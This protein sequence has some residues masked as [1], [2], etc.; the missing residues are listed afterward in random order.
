MSFLRGKQRKSKDGVSLR[1]LLAQ[2]Y[3]LSPEKLLK[4]IMPVMD[5]LKFYHD[6]GMVYGAITP[7]TLVLRGTVLCL[8]ASGTRLA[9]GIDM[10]GAPED[11]YSPPE[12]WSRDAGRVGPWSDTYALCAVVYEALTG[13]APDNSLIRI[14][15]DE[16]KTP[17]EIGI[18]LAPGVETV[19]MKGL[20]LEPEDRYQTAEELKSSIQDILNRRNRSR[21]IGKYA[22]YTAAVCLLVLGAAGAVRR[23]LEMQDPFYGRETQTVV[24]APVRELSEEAYKQWEKECREK[25]E[26]ICGEEA[27]RV[28]RRNDQ[29]LEITTFYHV[30]D[31]L[32]CK[33]VYEQ[34]FSKPFCPILYT[35]DPET[36]G[37]IKA[38]LDFEAVTDISLLEN[39]T[40]RAER[41][42]S[43]KLELKPEAFEGLRAEFDTYA[44]VELV[45]NE[46]MFSETYY[47]YAEVC[48]DEETSSII[49]G[50]D[51]QQDYW[52]ELLFYELSGGFDE[53]GVEAYLQCEIMADW[54]EV[55]EGSRYT[56]NYQCS[57]NQIPDPS[58]TLEYKPYEYQAA[59]A[60]EI[61]WLE[62]MID[63]KVRLDSLKQP[64]AVGRGRSDPTH[65]VIKTTMK[66]M[67]QM[68]V[69]TLCN[70][71]DQFSFVSNWKRMSDPDTIELQPGK[72]GADGG[73]IKLNYS[74]I[75]DKDD[76]RTFTEDM[77]KDGYNELF[78]K[79][80][81][82][83]IAKTEIAE[84]LTDGSVYFGQIGMTEPENISGK[85]RCYVDYMIAV[86]EKTRMDI[87]TMDLYD[88][89]WTEKDGRISS[90]SSNVSTKF[91]L[92]L[93]E[94]ITEKIE[95]LFPQTEVVAQD[96]DRYGSTVYFLT[97]LKEDVSSCEEA[98]GHIKKI[99]QEAQLDRGYYDNAYFYFYSDKEK[100]ERWLYMN[101]NKS[102]YTLEEGPNSFKI[103]WGID[104]TDEEALFESLIEEDEFFADM[105]S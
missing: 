71:S 82:Y 3:F 78:L 85:N 6:K 45:F 90:G 15:L 32:E 24:L 12:Q 20:A 29:A 11:H 22:V 48:F 102:V 46:S 60:G 42:Y 65:I 43:V 104:E 80:G 101:M 18:S 49:L 25:V 58:I 91:N 35:K 93:K 98:L 62:T 10:H 94:T 73:S 9:S 64:Y 87:F 51:I 79:L 69:D 81:S 59:D 40:S 28:K 14:L 56:G 5:Q 57:A 34:F 7:D 27:F 52:W 105:L 77:L 61:E 53:D 95:G 30:Y 37:K 72:T 89:A 33:A 66:N 47:Y 83:Y 54:E 16:L 19:L 26:M 38:P 67:D 84:P 74:E 68:V 31:E 17:S 100:T 55:R 2:G 76:L 41:E 92:G 75:Y 8:A 97:Y 39:Q 70:P 44:D 1:E 63:L 4:Y 13:I 23:Y 50:D 21:N 99:Y 103:Y 88:A 36:D 96:Q 86:A